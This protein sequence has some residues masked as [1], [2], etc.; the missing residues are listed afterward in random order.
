MCYW[1]KELI[2]IADIDLEIRDSPSFK[3]DIL[4]ILRFDE[5]ETFLGGSSLKTVRY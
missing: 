4:I 2:T 1:V 5:F 3:N